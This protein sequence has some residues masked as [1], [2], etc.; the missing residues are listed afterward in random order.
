[1][2]FQFSL[3]TLLICVTVLAVVAGISI[4][5]PVRDLPD[6]NVMPGISQAD[7]VVELPRRPSPVEV[8]ERV[9]TWGIPALAATLGVLWIVRWRRAGRER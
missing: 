6:P 1:M 9:L 8:L 3:A 5:V 7:S 4:A 2:R